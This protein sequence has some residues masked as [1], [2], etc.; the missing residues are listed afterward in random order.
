[1]KFIFSEPEK[2]TGEV[3]Y[4]RFNQPDFDPM[5]F[6][7][8]Q[9]VMGLRENGAFKDVR[10]AVFPYLTANPCFEEKMAEI[11]LSAPQANGDGTLPVMECNGFQL[12][13]IYE[14]ALMI[15]G[16]KISDPVTNADLERLKISQ[17]E[18]FK[19]AFQNLREW[20]AKQK[21]VIEKHDDHLRLLC[22]KNLKTNGCCVLL[23]IDLWR[24]LYNQL[25][26]PYYLFPLTRRKL[27]IVPESMAG[28]NILA[29]HKKLQDRISTRNLF[30]DAVFYYSDTFRRPIMIT[31]AKTM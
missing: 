25:G 29:A 13:C 26:E 6:L 2:E 19:T 11:I 31:L 23:L 14:W 7:S 9:Q 4:N 5:L 12:S 10:K 20:S 28:D 15:D 21:F 22:G 27:F 8:L 18:L 1:M 24:Q 16:V 3:S 17:D 30:S